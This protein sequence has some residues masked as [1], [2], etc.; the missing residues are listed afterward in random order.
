MF[1][2]LWAQVGCLF[3]G[4]LYH[5]PKPSYTTDSLLHYLESTVNEIE[6][7]YP[8]AGVV[9]AGD[10]NRLSQDSVAQRTGLA[11][12]VHQHTSLWLRLGLQRLLDL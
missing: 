5:P 10:F 6:R 1:E 7:D 3:V 12:I 4:V 8:G 2:L 9:L 11:Q